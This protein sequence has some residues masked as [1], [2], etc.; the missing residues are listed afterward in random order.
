MKAFL[1]KT[2]FLLAFLAGMLSTAFGQGNGDKKEKDCGE[3]CFSS[4]IIAVNELD[5]GCLEYTIRV[6]TNGA[7][8]HDLSHFAMDVPCGNVMDVSNSKGWAVSYGL[9]PTSELNGFKIDDIPSSA[10]YS[11]FE[12]TFTVCPEE[13]CDAAALSCWSPT[14]A[15]KAS[16]CVYYE[17]IPVVC[18]SLE[19]TVLSTDITCSGAGDGAITVEILDGTEPFAFTWSHDEALNGSVAEGLEAGEYSITVTDGAGENV[20]LNAVV[21]EPAPISVTSSVTNA[22]CSTNPDGSI[23][24]S[25]TG[26]ETPYSYQ[27]SHGPETAELTGVTPGIYI[28]SIVDANGCSTSKAYTVGV[29][30]QIMITGAVTQT[31]CSTDIGAIDASVTGG[32]GEYQYQWSNGETT[33]DIQDLSEGVYTLTVTDNSGCSELRT[34]YVTAKNTLRLSASRTNTSCVEDYSGAVDLT[35]TGGSGSYTYEWSNGEATEDIDGLGA[36]F[37]QVTVTDSEGCS[38]T[39]QAVIGTN[40]INVTGS[41]NQPTC[42]GAGDGSIM[43]TPGANE[44]ELSYEWSNGESGSSVS[45]LEPGVYSV[46]VS[47]A[48]GCEKTLT[49]VVSDPSLLSISASVTN[50]S[51]T[52]GSY[53]VDISVSGGSGNYSY[54]WD[55]GSEAEDRFSVNSGSY[56]IYVTD[57]NGCTQE[58]IVEVNETEANCMETTDPVDPDEPTDPNPD[59]PTDPNPDEPTAPNP[60]EPTDPNPDEPTDPNPDDPASPGNDGSCSDPYDAEVVLISRDGNC[61]TYEMTVTYDGNKSFGLSHVSVDVPCGDVKNITNT[62]GWKVSEGIDPTTGLDGFKIDDISG[63]GEGSFADEFTVEFTVCTQDDSCG[64][65]IAQWEPVVAFKYGQCVD[66]ENAE[67]S[68]MLST[69]SVYPNPFTTSINIT[70]EIPVN[71]RVKVE[72][73]SQAGLKKA[74]LYEGTLE[75]GEK[76]SWH[77]VPDS[78][79]P[80]GIYIY[81]I[82]SDAG[83]E[84][85]KIF[86]NK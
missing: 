55:D 80:E 40:T 11:D 37:Y 71:G 79:T 63:F 9:D 36:G 49:Y 6:S 75:G 13:A 34:F 39:L 54:A 72:I 3:S 10:G 68:S 26:G 27:W 48:D 35:V 77:W 25:A 31:G 21:S 20:E 81:R 65:N 67:R 4:E 19:A 47:N 53:D 57:E 45:G 76:A 22:S 83:I 1:Q 62:G 33:E 70:Y 44:G 78:S 64:E 2:T 12:V 73:F 74:E 51:C 29:E 46:T 69:A 14:V 38:S 66:T 86:L 16:T 18:R 41:V 84:Y 60:D 85:G 17:E 23:S 56:T 52:E 8:A 59:E 32:S 30:N 43:L 82:S 15:Y 7:C 58:M 28:L 61:F 5:G 42:N 50:E 24:V